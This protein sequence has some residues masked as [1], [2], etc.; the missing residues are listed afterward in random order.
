MR[1]EA[2]RKNCIS[3]RTFAEHTAQIEIVRAEGNMEQVVFPVPE[4]CNYLTSETKWQVF[5]KSQTDQKGSKITDF[6]SKFEDMYQEML[7]Q[8]NLRSKF[9]FQISLKIS[10]KISC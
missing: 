3:L 2:K 9:F 1:L 6:V 10:L 8:K 4:V 5:T 7:W